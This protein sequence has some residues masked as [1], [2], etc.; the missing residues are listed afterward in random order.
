MTML[1]IHNLHATVGE[2]QILNGLT[3]D[4]PAG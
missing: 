4:V 3:L 1:S 2:K